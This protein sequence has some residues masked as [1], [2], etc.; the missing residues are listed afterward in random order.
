MLAKKPVKKDKGTLK[1]GP[2][3]VPVV[4]P[5]REVIFEDTPISITAHRSSETVLYTVDAPHSYRINPFATET[6]K[7]GMLRYYKKPFYLTAGIHRL[8]ALS[9]SRSNP[10]AA[11]S[12]TIRRTFR[13][14]PRDGPLNTL[15]PRRKS[16]SAEAAAAAAG[17]DTQET[18][19]CEFVLF[20][21]QSGSMKGLGFERIRQAVRLMLRRMPDD[22]R[23]N[24]V[25]FGETAFPMWDRSVAGSTENV[26]RVIKYA[27]EMTTSQGGTNMAAALRAVFEP[28]QAGP[29]STSADGVYKR[30]STV[31]KRIPGYDR[32]LILLT[33]G[34]LQD[35]SEV[36]QLLRNHPY[37]RRLWI[38]AF[39]DRA[40][41]ILLNKIAKVG[42]G[43][44]E[45]ILSTDESIQPAV[46]RILSR[47]QAKPRQLLSAGMGS[48]DR[49]MRSFDK[50]EHDPEPLTAD[51]EAARA[52]KLAT[53]LWDSATVTF[54]ATALAAAL[55]EC[56]AGSDSA[57]PRTA[58][59]SRESRH[60]LP[61]GGPKAATVDVSAALEHNGRTAL[62]YAAEKGAVAV[63]VRLLDHAVGRAQVTRRDRSGRTPLHW[64]AWSGNLVMA[65][66]LVEKGFAPSDTGDDGGFTPAF[67]AQQEGHDE[68]AEYLEAAAGR[69]PMHHAAWNGDIAAAEALLAPTGPP[70]VE[71]YRTERELEVH[72]AAKAKKAA[73]MDPL[74]SQGLSPI[75]LAAAQ[76]H[77][78]VLALLHK[79]HAAEAAEVRKFHAG[80]PD[81]SA[82]HWA[83]F[84][85]SVE[86]CRHLIISGRD[87]DLKSREY[88]GITPAELAK[89][90]GKPAAAAARLLC[91]AEK[92]PRARKLGELDLS[93]LTHQ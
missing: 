24:L 59:G 18:V 22:C 4:Y 71:K 78:E 79:H 48:L 66:L 53:A 84:R 44:V 93:E 55:A 80:A 57:A 13:V 50:G 37:D 32:Q 2:V 17:P 1:G 40:N 86:W 19:A 92:L 82:L 42:N 3:K 28:K 5:P 68:V 76:G 39:G 72:E 11:P 16:A 12:P 20:V 85:G 33:D 30:S 21:D 25:G 36:L 54:D 62:A 15:K 6:E 61:S 7:N 51:Q 14:Q 10:H 46:R 70:L 73:V 58:G 26:V 29:A 83:A 43:G 38:C 90:R 89:S 23:L 8:A 47:A 67:L 91:A 45:Y 52:E 60:T 63:A 34:E 31:M 49:A 65:R 64:A 69:T 41:R 35:A 81:W 87:R 74:D 88:R 9:F 27:S 77:H 75:F 56:T